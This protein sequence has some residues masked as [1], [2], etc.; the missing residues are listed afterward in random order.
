MLCSCASL[1]SAQR[2]RVDAVIAARPSTLTC[3]G[4]NAC[5]RVSEV[6]ELGSR[7]LADSTPS[8]PHHY[9]VLLDRGTDALLARIDLIRS[10]TKSIDLQTY[11]F[12]ED[13]SGR[14]VLD[15]LIT[16]ARRGVRVRVL[17]DQLSALKRV[18]TL[19]ALS[20]VHSNFD[21]R[22]YNPVLDRAR[23]SYPHYLLAS[24]C[25]W[26]KLNHRMHTKLLLIDDDVGITGGR[27]YADDYYDWDAQYDFRDRDVVIAG[28]VAHSMG[29]QFDRYWDDR[30]SV[31][32]QHLSDVAGMLLS[33]G[34][35][36]LPT[37][38]YDQPERVRVA[39]EQAD[40]AAFVH[41]RIAAHALRVGN[42]EY[43]SDLPGKP[44]SS[45]DMSPASVA[46]RELIVGAKDRVLLQTPYLVLSKPAR[47][48]FRDLHQ[49][50]N[51]PRVI[52][53]TSSLA[54]TDAFIAYA[55][56]YKYKRRYLR[57]YGFEIHEFKP[58]PQDVP[59]DIATTG[60]PLPGASGT[61]EPAPAAVAAPY[62][63]RS[64]VGRRASD[65]LPRRPLAREFGAIAY[66]SAR[67]NSPVP[68]TR[69]GLRMGLHAKSMVIDETVGVVGT[70]NFDPRG[71]RYNTESVLVVHDAA[72]ARE[73]AASIERDNLPANAWVIA[74][75]EKPVVLSGVNYSLG[76]LSEQ[77]PLF[78][79][80]P[81]RYATSYEFKPS[82]ECPG[83]L[84]PGDPDFHRCYQA[85][86]DFPEVALGF[87]N[88]ITRIVTAFGAGL[89]P[90]F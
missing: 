20:G 61:P 21:V 69:D 84:P 26:R 38:H 12:D 2:A 88:I 5:A 32:V 3:A 56:A 71:E 43:I 27:N 67:A 68:L 65:R 30:R 57:D 49:R 54:S 47:R 39:G 23:I 31:P 80:Y 36:A 90:V 8:V 89:A 37:P 44:G 19:A 86:G 34:V 22:I 17:I 55:L 53:S 48:M 45:H 77:L 13:D 11:I 62:D 83:P 75:R 58:F 25:C 4:A 6:H 40:D 24:A 87:R 81:L 15:E 66:S 79:F 52:V 82:P 33:T 9:T 72:F 28:P 78:D 7:A 74:P 60:A 59:F 14:F 63:R 51:P 50:P 76:K 10:A 29:S 42:V 46:L 73:L 18:D 35:P 70:H 85:A 41:E 1:G 64:V 16:A